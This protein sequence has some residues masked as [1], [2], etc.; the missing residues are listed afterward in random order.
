MLG[1][2]KNVEVVTEE[3]NLNFAERTLKR[4]NQK[5]IDNEMNIDSRFLITRSNICERMFP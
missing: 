1:G 3:E 4:E 2:S 5:E